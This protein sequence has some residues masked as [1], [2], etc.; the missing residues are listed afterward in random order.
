MRQEP[1]GF[2]LPAFDQLHG[3]HKRPAGSS[4]GLF[5]ERDEVGTVGL[6]TDDKVRQAAT[7]VRQGKVFSLNWDLDSPAPAILGRESLEHEVIPQ[8]AGFD[9]RYRNFF[10]QASS[11]WDSLAHVRHPLHGFYNGFE[12]GEVDGTRGRHLGIDNWARR[13]IVGRFVFAD[14]GEYR[15]R[16]G[17]PIDCSQRTAVAAEEIG[18]VLES[19]GTELQGADILLL[20]FGWI[21]WYNDL[22]DAAKNLLGKG[23]LFPSPGLAATK[24]TA[25]W[26]WDKSIAA[27]AGDC[28]A[29]EAMPFDTADAD[30]FLHYRLIPLLG[31]AVG[32]MFDLETLST[33]CASDGIYEGMFTAAPLNKAGGIG[34]P[35]NA[36]ALK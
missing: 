25:Q 21:K 23:D 19:Q 12:R 35:A 3:D 5:G 24:Q 9:D 15:R 18:H 26:L 1:D 13:G 14:V 30:G 20:R 28:P 4:W 34:S 2:S 31:M 7:L 29:L 17:S 22:D 6:L 16:N 32:E 11:Q 36:L 33:D 10:P 27:V 8:D